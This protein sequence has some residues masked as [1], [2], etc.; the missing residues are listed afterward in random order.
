[1]AASFPSSFEAKGLAPVISFLCRQTVLSDL[2]FAISAPQLFN[3]SLTLQ[4]EADDRIA[5][6]AV[7]SRG[8]WLLNDPNARHGNMTTGFSSA[9]CAGDL[10]EF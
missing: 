4:E 10:F 7:K 6:K 5:Q 8:S 3:F 1:M 2:I 9:F